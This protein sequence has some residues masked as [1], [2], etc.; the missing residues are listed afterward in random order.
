MSEQ[1]SIFDNLQS[2]G[3]EKVRSPKSVARGA[4]PKC[5]NEKVGLLR[6][7]DG[8]HLIWRQH[9]L[10][11]HGGLRIPCWSTALHLCELPARDIPGLDTPVCPHPRSYQ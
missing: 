9:N 4:C 11:T 10:V 1:P 5:S 3:R 8:Q 2:G 6:S 7:P